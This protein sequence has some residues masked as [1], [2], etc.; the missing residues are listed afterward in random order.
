MSQ[1]KFPGV[2]TV[3]LAVVVVTLPVHPLHAA[4]LT[5]DAL[6]Q[7][8]QQL[9]QSESYDQ[10]ADRYQA[11]LSSETR[12][13]KRAKAALLAANCL[14]R[15]GRSS[16]SIPLLDR[17]IAEADNLL[18]QNK[19]GIDESWTLSALYGKAVAC[20]KTG[21]R[22]G[23]LK[24]IERIRAQFFKSDEAREA[25]TIQARLEGWSPER[26]AQVLARE[27]EAMQ[28]AEQAA[29][30]SKQKRHKEALESC[31]RIIQQYADT[32]AVYPAMRTKALVL[33]NMGGHRQAKAVYQAILDRVK[34]IAPHSRLVRTAE[35]RVAWYDAIRMSETLVADRR[36]HLE[37][38]DSRWQELRDLCQ[39]VLDKDPSPEER[40]DAKVM[41]IV[42]YAW[43]DRPEE[44]LEAAEAFLREY[45]TDKKHAKFDYQITSVRLYAGVTAART[46]RYSEG[47]KHLDYVLD[48]GLRLANERLR[49]HVLDPAYFWRWHIL[50]MSGATEDEV[51]E[52]VREHVSQLPG[53]PN[54]RFVQF[55]TLKQERERQRAVSTPTS[56]P[57]P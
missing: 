43:Q 13:K 19:P 32:A 35:Y 47:L 44:T 27:Q 29:E 2:L 50:R 37:V 16:E 24:A 56:Q 10:A 40:A 41:I 7:E 53:A 26:L 48:R 52:A 21:D 4:E 39:V 38:T 3:L 15:I 18:A 14:D 25:L 42:S 46:G 36:K 54:A 30:A 31:D 23:A 28:M 6:W 55:Y 17:A 57:Q 20:E 22:A 33:W 1:S 9:E 5:N 8:A 34:P 45:D 51:R 49:E 12:W 11:I